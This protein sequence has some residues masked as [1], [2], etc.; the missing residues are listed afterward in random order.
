MRFIKNR[1]LNDKW[2]RL[3]WGLCRLHI[4]IGIIC[5]I[6]TL[7]V[8]LLIRDTTITSIVIGVAVTIIVTCIIEG[9][10]RYINNR[11][12]IIA[13]ERKLSYIYSSII[14]NMSVFLQ[15][16]YNK[17]GFVNLLCKNMVNLYNY[18]EY[19]IASEG[20]I[21]DTY[22]IKRIKNTKRIVEEY[23][24]DLKSLLV[25]LDDENYIKETFKTSISANGFV[26]ENF[27]NIDLN[28][29]KN[30]FI[31]DYLNID[32]KLGIVIG[33]LNEIGIC[34]REYLCIVDDI[35]EQSYLELLTKNSC[36][37]IFTAYN[38]YKIKINKYNVSNIQKYIANQK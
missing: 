9:Y 13:I 26:I 18:L 4:I 27:N 1:L 11:Q 34:M 6:C 33:T 31:D 10:N 21:L 20:A 12:K 5:I 32:F 14:D 15:N 2:K 30:K 35:F 8:S 7:L 3:V 29:M 28:I 23:I 25:V 19:D 24:G 16:K 37:E 22:D 36:N 17:H 38:I